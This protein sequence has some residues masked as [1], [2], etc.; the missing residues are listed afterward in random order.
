MKKERKKEE[1]VMEQIM[2]GQF[3]N[4]FWKTSG[5]FKILISDCTPK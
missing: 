3:E 4:Q 1:G 5:L 2:Q